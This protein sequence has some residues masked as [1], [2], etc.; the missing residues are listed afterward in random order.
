[1]PL[2]VAILKLKKEKK[3]F[4]LY[5]NFCSQC[6]NEPLSIIVIDGEKSRKNRP[7][8]SVPM[9]IYIQIEKAKKFVFGIFIFVMRYFIKTF[10]HESLLFSPVRMFYKCTLLIHMSK[11]KAF[12]WLSNYPY[13]FFNSN[14]F[15]VSS[16]GIQSHFFK[17]CNN[18]SN[19]RC[20]FSPQI[21]KLNKVFC[22]CCLNKMFTCFGQT[23]L[24]TLQYM[25]LTLVLPHWIIWRK[26]ELR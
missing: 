1:M 3:N 7:M 2:T 17:Y 19:S 22:V 8:I 4:S 10:F 15:P 18:L 26:F 25:S 9:R 21:N 14:H 12:E 16:S 11:S 23:T 6:A 24:R 5:T 13:F 20:N